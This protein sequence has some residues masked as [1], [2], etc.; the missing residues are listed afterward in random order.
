MTNRKIYENV[1]LAKI[2][3]VVQQTKIAQIN[4]TLYENKT[5]MCIAGYVNLLHCK[6]RKPP[7]C[8]GHLL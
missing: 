7:T 3:S 8:F 1:C 4:F 2:R 5:S 6:C